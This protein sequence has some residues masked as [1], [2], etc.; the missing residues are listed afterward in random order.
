MPTHTGYQCVMKHDN[1]SVPDV[2]YWVHSKA[3]Y[4]N[5]A[6]I[7]AAVEEATLSS[8]ISNLNAQDKF[9][10]KNLKSNDILVIS[11]GGNDIALRPTTG[12]VMAMAGLMLQPMFMLGYYNPA[13]MHFGSLFKTTLEAYILKLT[14]YKK[15][16][17][18]IICFL[19][20]PD[21]NSQVDSWANSTLATLG[22]N[23][24][25]KTLQDRMKLIFE[26]CVKQIQVKRNIKFLPLFEVLNGKRTQDYVKR[27]EPS[28]SGGKKIATKIINFII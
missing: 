8:K 7:N 20:F 17:L 4:H 11:I 24:N 1:Q 2:A 22:Y 23:R 13:I 27:V 19:Y 18:I 14:H 28:G 16:R 3:Q 10:M 25:P 9:I 6:C 5:M 12:T 15:P 21:E 26:M